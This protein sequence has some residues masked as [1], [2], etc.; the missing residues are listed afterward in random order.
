MTVGNR[1]SLASN[2][3]FHIADAVIIPLHY[4]YGMSAS[5]SSMSENNMIHDIS[6]TIVTINQLLWFDPDES[7]SL[8][9]E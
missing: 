5:L 9:Q 4:F 3:A 6:L 7:F 8:A 2:G 1:S